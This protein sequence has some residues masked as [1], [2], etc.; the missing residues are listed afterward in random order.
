MPP[1]RQGDQLSFHQEESWMPVL[2]HCESS[3]FIV[4]S[5]FDLLFWLHT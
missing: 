1:L 5:P 3:F 2:L 4:A